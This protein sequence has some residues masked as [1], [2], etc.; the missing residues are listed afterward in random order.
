[1]G[2][3]TDESVT[4]DYNTLLNKSRETG[5]NILRIL[6]D[7]II[8]VKPWQCTIKDVDSGKGILIRRYK[9]KGQYIA[10][11]RLLN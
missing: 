11:R 10:Y 1:M 6:Y 7:D 8:A 9:G 3:Y 4:I 5:R 2:I